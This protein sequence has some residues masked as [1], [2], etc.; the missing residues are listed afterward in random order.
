MTAEKLS[1][2]ERLKSD[3]DH[4]R[5]EY[6]TLEQ[7]GD[8]LIRQRDTLKSENNVLRSSL[9]WIRERMGTVDVETITRILEYQTPC[10]KKFPT[11]TCSTFPPTTRLPSSL[12]T[13]PKAGIVLTFT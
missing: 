3:R 8:C 1:E 5:N 2:I 13:K 4:W 6:K 10:T 11:P 9:E 7:A 12:S